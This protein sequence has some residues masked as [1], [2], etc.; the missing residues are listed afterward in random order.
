MSKFKD[1]SNTEFKELFIIMPTNNYRKFHGLPMY[2]KGCGHTTI[3][4]YLKVFRRGRR[5]FGKTKRKML[6]RYRMFCK[7]LYTNRS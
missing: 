5:S 6:Q 4:Q 1:V 2:R 7:Q 3:T